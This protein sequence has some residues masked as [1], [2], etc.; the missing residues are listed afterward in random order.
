MWLYSEEL[1]VKEIVTVFTFDTFRGTAKVRRTHFG[2]F[3]KNDS[4]LLIFQ[5]YKE[6]RKKYSF[7]ANAFGSVNNKWNWPPRRPSIILTSKMPYLLTEMVLNFSLENKLILK[8]LLLNC[9]EIRKI[10]LLRKNTELWKTVGIGEI[11]IN[12][13][14]VNNKLC[15]H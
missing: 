14:I 2:K 1:D 7:G 13:C 4:A 8:F 15:C 11:T 3:S 6:M 10:V 5:S 9:L 12:G